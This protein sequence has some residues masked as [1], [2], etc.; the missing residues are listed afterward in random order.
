MKKILLIIL[1]LFTFTGCDNEEVVLETNKVNLNEQAISDKIINDL[2]FYNTSIIYE[3]GMT[4]FK[5]NLLNN[6]NDIQINNI[7][8]EFYS[9]NKTLIL[10]L[11]K[12]VDRIIKNNEKIQIVLATDID[13][14]DIYEVKYN[15]D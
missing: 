3:K 15:I 5:S 1:V 6:G 13:L 11:V 7:N 10:T 9:K 12:K 14:T 8:I 2:K 4:T